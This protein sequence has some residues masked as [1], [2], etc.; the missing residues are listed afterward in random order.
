MLTRKFAVLGLPISH[1]KSPL[2]HNAA[3]A[4]LGLDGTYS[5][6][7][8]EKGQL[9]DFL[10]EYTFDA[11]S[12]TMPLK[13]EAYRLAASADANATAT[14]VAN[15]I[16]RRTDG[17]SA[18]NTDVLGFKEILS[19]TFSSH[20]ERTVVLGAGSTAKSALLALEQMGVTEIF[21]MA[22]NPDAVADLQ[23]IFTSLK[24]TYLD[25]ARPLSGFS[26]VISAVP[27][28]PGIAFDSTIE[29]LI[30]V[31]YQ[32]STDRLCHRLMATAPTIVEGLD[33]L[34]FQAAHQVILMRDIDASRYDEI[35]A[36]MFKA[37]SSSN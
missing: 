12:I 4:Y 26:L 19:R 34:V 14:K 21:V 32:D 2:L 23:G 7:Q 36:V 9:Q 1:S 25:W 33:L 10:H 28:A 22:R 31:T 29:N 35:V 11:V 17:W 16:V 24:I 3:Y 6:W 37:L 8:V 15:T 20:L 18:H 27:T 30:D 5:K 13:E